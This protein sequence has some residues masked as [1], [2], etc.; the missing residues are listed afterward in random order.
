MKQFLRHIF[1]LLALFMATASAWGDDCTYT[2][3]L[4]GG[5]YTSKDFN[6]TICSTTSEAPNVA[7]SIKYTI[8]LKSTFLGKDLTYTLYAIDSSGQQHQIASNLEVDNGKTVTV[9][10][11]FNFDKDITSY[12][13]DQT[14]NKF[15]GDRD[16]TISN[17]TVTYKYAPSLTT[18]NAALT[19]EDTPVGSSSSVSF[20]V[21]FQNS[22]NSV[23]F[24]AEESS[25]A[26]NSFSIS[27]TPKSI[28]DCSGTI[29]YII[30]FS[31]QSEQTNATATYVISGNGASLTVTVTATSFATVKPE[32]TCHIANSYMVDDSALNLNDLWTSTS[33]AQK[34]YNIVSWAPS[35]SNNTNA[36]QPAITNNILSLGQAGTLVLSLSQAETTGYYADSDTKTITINKYDVDASISQSSALRNE[37]INNPFSLSY[38]LTDFIVESKNTNI[39]EYHEFTKQIQTYFTDGTASFQITRLEDY[40]YNKLNKT[41][42]LNVTQNTNTC[43]VLDAPNEHSFTCSLVGEDQE[44]V[45]GEFSGVPYQLYFEAET[46]NNDRVGNVKVQQYVNNGWQEIAEINPNKGYDSYGPYD[47]DETATKI[48]F[49]NTYG[50]YQR[51]F[52]NVRV[53][54]K[55][56]LN[57]QIDGETFYLTQVSSGMQFAGTFPLEWSTCSDEI[58]FSCDNP[59]YTII[60]SV[61]DASSGQGTTSIIV[62]YSANTENPVLTGTLTIYDQSQTKTITLSCEHLTQTIDWPQYFYNLEADENG[63]INEDITLNA[64][65]RTVSGQPTNQPIQYTL[66]VSPANA[67]LSTDANGNTLLHIT[68]MCEGTITAAVEGFTDSNGRTYTASSLTRQIRIR[69]A[70][71]P[72]H[73]YALYIV[74]L[75]TITVTNS[76]KIF[77]I[78]G[79][80]ENT[81]TFIAHTDV[82]S[83]NNDL[84]IDFSKDGNTWGN[85]QTIDIK[86]DDKH[87]TYSCSVPD[88]VSFIRFKTGSTFRTFFDMVTI[89]QKEYLT[90]SVDHIDFPNTIVN[91]S[92]STT[93]TVDY[94]DVPFIQYDV[95]N[96]HNLNLQLTPSPE[97]NNNCGEYGT[98]TFTLTGMSPYPQEDVTET[99]TIFTSAGHRVEIPITI[100]AKLSETYYFNKQDG[101]WSDLNNWQV[102]G[103]NPPSRPTPSNPVVITKAATIGT[104]NATFEGIAYSVTMGEGGSLTVLPKGGLTVYAGGISGANE[105]NLILHNKKD[106]AGFIRI[107]PYFTKEVSGTMPKVKVLYETTST[108]DEGANELAVWQYIGAPGADCQFTVDYIT[109]LYH[110]SETQ[111]WINKTGKLTLEPFA[112]YA[113]TQYGKPTYE[114]V[115]QPINSNQ[116]IT[117]TKTDTG[118]G[119]N[120][121]NLFSNSYMTPI[122]VKNF[123]KED[124]EGNIEATFYL[125][126][127]GSYSDWANHNNNNNTLGDN[128]SVSPGQY[129]AIPALA[130]EYLPSNFDITTIPPMQGVY[131]IAKENNAK[132][133]LNYN[134][135]V[136]NAGTVTTDMHEPMRAPSHNVFKTDNFRRLRIQVNSANSGAD[137]MYVIQDTITTTDYDNGYDAPNQLAEGLANIYTN[138]HFGQMEVSC[139]NHIDS[140]FI[141]FTAGSD[142]I[143]TLTFNAIIGEDLHIQDLDNDS[144]ILLEE[145]ATYTFRATPNSKNEL[146]FQILLYPERDL[147][148]GEEEKDDIY[149]DI[150]D[151]HTIQVWLHGRCIYINN[152]PTNTIA[153]LFNISGYKLLTTPIHH[154]PYTLDLNYLPKGVY[155][156]QL[157]TQVYKFII[158]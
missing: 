108:L 150:T 30:T 157:N 144:I 90:A 25:D 41:L 24:A 45:P 8:D 145:G 64:V 3:N 51:H 99:I 20:S 26:N 84:S 102:N 134:R 106:G 14:S 18:S 115:A 127:S 81:M 124:F 36:V 22:T 28:T 139:S 38:G 116:T 11:S 148:F 9:E 42:T 46:N 153:T 107:S 120:G 83:V 152:A 142:S 103:I 50:S 119:M 92:F 63:Y 71:T 114:L 16:I 55:T 43:N 140:T 105:N 4:N 86:P 96:N 122:D 91:Q 95:T 74:D 15:G 35:G 58:R 52:R 155:M 17:V 118:S 143:Y 69:K 29:E 61:I 65:A 126:N 147:D 141:G 154:T 60:P 136:W 146:R 7:V 113:I 13:I 44:Y 85:K 149:T 133:H 6:H 75:Q 2:K 100:T 128:H 78:N 27:P 121:D 158:Q 97:I 33:P 70:G 76:T 104:D 37:I 40:K 111:G 5:S 94:S 79:L 98:Y 132:I 135:H 82:L 88:N 56:F 39:A 62:T 54:R 68:G 129:C 32:Y 130:A 31:P 53:T 112:G 57:P 49:F 117:L 89:H 77:S 23:T 21:D 19:I 131:V 73:S 87:S 59:N 138:E 12:K 156:L 47:L 72:C 48:R 10:K 66:S 67:S 110:W 151:I 123:K 125:F 137:R 101:D 109:W 34:K 1:L 93:F 80:P